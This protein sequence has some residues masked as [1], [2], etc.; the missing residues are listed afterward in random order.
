M[1]YRAFINDNLFYDSY[2]NDEALAL[3]SASISYEVNSAGLFTFTMLPSNNLYDGIALL[4][5]YVKVYRDDE[6][7]FYGRVYSQS[8]DLYTQK[9]V[10]C[11]GI[12][13]VFNDSIVRPF[14]H[15]DTLENLLDTLLQNHNSQVSGE[16]QVQLGNI[17]V[18]DEITFRAYEKHDTTISRLQDLIDSYGGIMSVRLEDD[19][20]YL[21]W[22]EEA[23]GTAS[24]HIN[25]GE[26]ILDITR[27]V[28]A[29][30][31]ITVLIP[32]GA[33]IEQED[34]TKKRLDITSVNNG[35]DYIEAD[36][37]NSVEQYPRIVGTYTWDD[38]TVPA[39]L[40]S[41]GQAYLNSKILSK[42][43]INVN[44]IDLAGLDSTIDS[45]KIGEF[46]N[47]KSA[48]HGINSLFL[49]TSQNLNLLDA[50]QNTMT[51]GAE[52]FGFV[53][54]SVRREQSTSNTI[55]G[56]NKNYATNEKINDVRDL[57]GDVRTL[58]ANN[59]TAIEQNAQEIA[60]KADSTVTDSLGNRLSAVESQVV[61]DSETLGVYFG[62]DGR[63]SS[64]FTFDENKFL[65]GRQGSAIHS[66][67]DNQSYRF[68]NENGDILLEINPDGTV[69]K[70]VNV[71]AQV[72]FV[73]GDYPQ[74][75]MRKGRYIDGKG[76]NLNDVWIGG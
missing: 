46:I 5:D 22:Y 16:R 9:T 35:L 49:C 14:T 25:F 44:A 73:Q 2:S 7:I 34:G 29:D 18:S 6:L 40:K 30:E 63:I 58:V 54:D 32:L 4:S 57:V 15:N 1:R 23:Q 56:I 20:L 55:E 3:A 51:L 21:D 48:A 37:P 38:V 10:V 60:L 24:Q 71:S 26:N 65:I 27:E 43:T 45:F 64:W 76:I 47:V 68:V 41:K 8:K 36:V 12:F 19:V 39:I 53:G 67:Q 74:W 42:T 52:V 17:E 61:L 72:R 69:S 75:A 70:T 28:N 50:S 66:E 59:T 13:A 31:I 33:E 11:E 62:S